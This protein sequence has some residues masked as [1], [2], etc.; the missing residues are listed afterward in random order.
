[1]NVIGSKAV[2]L[3][4]YCR[5]GHFSARPFKWGTNDRNWLTTAWTL[6]IVTYN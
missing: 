2:F 6:A 5:E 3:V 1:M 4:I